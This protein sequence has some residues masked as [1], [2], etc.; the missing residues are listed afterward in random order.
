[1][2]P[3]VKP[4]DVETLLHAL[5]IADSKGSAVRFMSQVLNTLAIDSETDLV[6][7]SYRT[8]YI[9]GLLKGSEYH[10]NS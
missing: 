1:M 8:L 10:G 6:N 2:T 9:M 4:E 7:E 5:R 3:L